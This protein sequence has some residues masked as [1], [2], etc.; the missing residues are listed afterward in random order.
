MTRFDPAWLDRQYNNRER[1]PDHPKIFARW[2]KASALAREKSVC[3]LDLPYGKSPGETLDVFVPNRERAPI[4]VF[5]H[6]GYWRALDKRDVSFIAPSFVQDGAMVLVPNYALCPAVS[7]DTI[8]LQ[9]VKA[10]EWAYRNA[11]TYG[12]DRERIVVAGHSAGGHLATMML[13]CEWDRVGADLPRTLVSSAM[14]ISGLFDLE[15]IRHVPFLKDDL[16]LTEASALRMSP[17]RFPAPSGVLHAL[18]GGLESEEFL[19]Q[20]R[21]IRDAWGARAVPVCE[22]IAGTNHLDVLHDFADSG[23]RSHMLALELLGL[24]SQGDHSVPV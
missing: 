3:Q 19:R 1:I 8:T 16:G 15:P 6:G 2:E 5:I 24:A 23:G 9:M 10:V 7:V 14:S 22:S 4:L 12:A 13:T 18:V 20:N 17:A 21:L 11:A